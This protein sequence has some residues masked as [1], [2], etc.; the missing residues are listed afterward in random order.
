MFTNNSLLLSLL[1]AKWIFCLSLLFVTSHFAFAFTD[2]TKSSVK[3]ISVEV[4]SVNGDEQKPTL[5]GRVLDAS[6][7][8]VIGATVLIEN[9]KIGTATDLNGQFYF[10][11]IKSGT[12]RLIISAIGFKT[13]YQDVDVL[14]NTPKNV[15]IQFENRVWDLPEVMVLGVSDRV[16]SKVPG[17]ATFLNSK[18]IR[19]IAPLS[20]NEVFRR[21]TGVHVV[22]EEGLGMRVNVGIRGLDPDRSRN[23]LVLEDGIPVALAPYGEPEMY[24]TP[25]MDR[26]S[27]VEILKGSGQILFGPQTIGGVIN[28]ISMNPPSE[29]EGLIRINAGEGGYFNT[30]LSYGNTQG[31]V[32]YQ[33]NFLKKRADEVGLTGFDINDFNS[34]IVL[35][36]SPKSNLSFKTGI[37][38]EVSNSTY[39]GLTQTMFDRGGQ[40]FVHM[41]PDDEL[42]VRRY[43]ASIVHDY[44]FSRNL[45]LKTTAFG[46]T[47][48]R[49]WRRQDFALNGDQNRKPANW[50]GVTWGDES[51]PNGAVYMRNS[52]GNRNRQFEVAGIEPR[53]EANHNLLGLENQLKVGARYLCERAFEQRV[54]GTK[55]NASSGNLV[56][57]EIRTGNALSAYVQNQTNITNQL[58]INLGVRIENFDY[59]R[60]IRR[61]NFDIGGVT[62]LRDTILL[63]NSS[64]NQ[65]IPGAGFNWKIK[66]QINLF[67]GVHMGFAPPRTK[68]AISGSGIVYELDAE[69]S[70][71][72]ELG[73][74]SQIKDIL[75][76]ELTG[77]YMDFSN[78]IIP[79][80]ES[81][82]GAGAGLV[83]GGS[84]IH[85]GIEFAANLQIGRLLSLTST[86]INL[87]ANIT[88]I[89]ARFTGDRQQGGEKLEGN[90]TP[91]APN[92]IINSALTIETIS[93]FDFRLGANF[94]GDQFTD[95]LNTVVPSANGTI[96]EIS[97]YFTM[98]GT[99]AYH[100]KKWN[101]AFSLSV[102]NITN[103]RYLVSRRPQGIRVGLPR[104]ISAGVE[105]KF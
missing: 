102:K 5:S 54:N 91:Y 52:T 68:D 53:L 18:E 41:A 30:L 7:E 28:Y 64:L 95:V 104:F 63:R 90:R 85:Q 21:A 87:D 8:P 45:R 10:Y 12:Y 32:G 88:L 43:S 23:V 15:D 9:T 49:N 101:T 92:Y 99:V 79:V 78:Q 3:V 16:F 29:A 11:N 13:I 72:Y 103:E 97:A 89:D 82:G 2:S 73:L 62:Q 6:N 77:F 105:Y 47:T 40:D 39:I 14:E 59:E 1:S 81:S 38:N 51:V 83:N 60:D 94:I 58:S 17:S 27:G 66:E 44:R 20:G 37:Y 70:I 71:N 75:F 98:D 67:G 57:D 65:L 55:A 34:K 69:Q 80:A 50:T 61:R 96:G 93:G 26:M 31:N 33:L 46:F 22:D 86:A 76:V 36:L 42:R 74:R 25:V 4:V 19:Q 56:E 84:T 48:T 35:N 24:Y 100:V